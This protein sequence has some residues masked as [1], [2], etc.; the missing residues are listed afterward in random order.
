MQGY[1]YTQD[2]NTHLQTPVNYCWKNCWVLACDLTKEPIATGCHWNMLLRKAFG[3]ALHFWKALELFL[4]T[5]INL[6]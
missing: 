3:E 4:D 2:T 6:N 5:E 1:V